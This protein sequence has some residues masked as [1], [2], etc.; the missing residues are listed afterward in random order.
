M[1]ARNRHRLSGLVAVASLFAL[2]TFPL[3]AHQVDPTGA[4]SPALAISAVMATGTVAELVV[5]N[6][7]SGV[8]LR[9]LALRI[10]EGQTVALT[11]AGLDLLAGGTRVTAAGSLAGNVMTVTSV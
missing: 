8:R 11:G 6:R 1:P 10:D 9:Y 4:S 3:P 2:A 5:D 7:V